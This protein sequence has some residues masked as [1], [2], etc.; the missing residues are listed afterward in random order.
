MAGGDG[1]VV[2]HVDPFDRAIHARGNR[3]EVAID[4]G[5]VG[6]FVSTRVQVK[7]YGDDEHYDSDN[8]GDDQRAAF[9]CRVWRR[10]LLFVLVVVLL[11]LV[12][13][14]SLAL[15]LSLASARIWGAR[16]WRCLVAALIAVLILPLLLALLLLLLIVSRHGY[17]AC[18]FKRFGMTASA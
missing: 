10:L 7:T 1:L 9:F 18:P 4:L 2:F 17:C 11:A 12:L 14:L 8:A 13:T 5:V 3:I 16:I 6:V 15:V